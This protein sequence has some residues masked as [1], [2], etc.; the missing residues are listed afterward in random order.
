MEWNELVGRLGARITWILIC[1]KLASALIVAKCRMLRGFGNL[2]KRCFEKEITI[3]T[4]TIC[5]GNLSVGG[6]GKTSVTIA[7]RKLLSKNYKNIFVL[8]RGY[9]SLNRKPKIVS[10][11]DTAKE[12][13]DEACVHKMYGKI[14]IARNRK[15]G[16]LLCEKLMSDLIILDDGFQSKNIK[17]DISIVV[18]ESDRMFGN[19]KS[20]AKRISFAH[21]AVQ[22]RIRPQ[23]DPKVTPR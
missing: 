7:V 20:S 10:N 11:H 18:F 22:N 3:K 2:E 14:C 4:P 6:S 15:E 12:V 8:S 21:G 13:G 17:K 16:A 19:E 9:K 5:I 1:E 23:S